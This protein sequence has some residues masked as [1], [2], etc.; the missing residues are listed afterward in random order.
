[1]TSNYELKTKCKEKLNAIRSMLSPEER[2]KVETHLRD[3]L[4]ITKGLM[5]NAKVS[6]EDH[7]DVVSKV[8][9][10]T[11]EK[12]K[13]D[14]EIKTLRQEANTASKLR[15]QIASL[16]SRTHELEQDSVYFEALSVELLCNT[17]H[18]LAFNAV[19]LV[20]N[21]G[22]VLLSKW[23]EGMARK[24]DNAT[25]SRAFFLTCLFWAGFTFD[26]D[27][28]AEV[29]DGLSEIDAPAKIGPWLEEVRDVFGMCGVLEW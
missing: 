28:V 12:N 17:L 19:R 13:K 24:I 27:K 9:T 29:V 18:V 4:E 21:G 10:L 3:I 20:E 25:D 7:H 23:V 26:D 5:D 1:M 11:C 8:A 14:E 15:S 2:Q 6:P 22:D 16:T